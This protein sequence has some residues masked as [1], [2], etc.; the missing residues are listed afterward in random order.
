M[1]HA[2]VHLRLSEGLGGLATPK[3]LTQ[4]VR[5]IQLE[6]AAHQKLPSR[7]YVLGRTGHL[8]IINID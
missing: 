3:V 6:S 1:F 5:W 8:E 4:R 2:F 7:V